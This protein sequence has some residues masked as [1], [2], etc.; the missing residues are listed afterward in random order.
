LFKL[1]NFVKIEFEEGVIKLSLN[2]FADCGVEG[3]GVSKFNCLHEF[4]LTF[5]LDVVEIVFGHEELFVGLEQNDDGVLNENVEVVDR[6]QY[7]LLLLA[8][9][10][11]GVQILVTVFVQ[12]LLNAHRL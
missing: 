9:T 8:Q 3:E 11:H 5:V 2:F 10:P 6:S 4:V 7:Q 1:L 12:A